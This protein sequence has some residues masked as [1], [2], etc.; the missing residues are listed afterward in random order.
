MEIKVSKSHLTAAVKAAR[1]QDDTY[2]DVNQQ[3]PIAQAIRAAQ[4]GKKVNVYGEL[5]EL[6]R[7]GV[8]KRYTLSKNGV[9][10][11]N[12]F[13]KIC[14]LMSAKITAAT[15]AKIAKLCA[16]PSRSLWKSTPTDE[17]KDKYGRRT[18]RNG[19]A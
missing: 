3:C 12:R 1:C 19:L 10:L 2:F 16:A 8:V 5:V 6:S 14:P 9:T 18:P 11:I 13:D 7:N 17:S 15:K 4:P